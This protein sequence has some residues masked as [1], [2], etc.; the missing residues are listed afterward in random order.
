MKFLEVF[1]VFGLGVGFGFLFTVV[2]YTVA[3]QDAYLDGR[4]SAL[5]TVATVG[6]PAGPCTIEIPL[7]VL[8]DMVSMG[9]IDWHARCEV[10]RRIVDGGK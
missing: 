3:L 2:D 1:M 5:S 8:A 4:N 9:V 6:P 7:S 10:L